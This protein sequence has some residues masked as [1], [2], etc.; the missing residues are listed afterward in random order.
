MIL[1]G[2][3]ALAMAGGCAQQRSWASGFL[4]NSEQL[5]ATGHGDDTAYVRPRVDWHTYNSIYID[6]VRIKPAT[7]DRMNVTEKEQSELAIYLQQATIEAFSGRF[8]VVNKPGPHAIRVRAAITEVGQANPWVNVPAAILAY[9]VDYGGVSVEMEVLDGATG[10]RLCALMA[11][12]TGDPMQFIENY[13][14]LGHTRRGLERCAERLRLVV[15]ESAT[16]T[17]TPLTAVA[18]P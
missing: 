1:S 5:Q 10:Q 14:W 4:P 12:R 3:M 16:Q 2:V 11:S 9:P 13:T 6:P 7:P 15:D 8:A 17:L 18:V